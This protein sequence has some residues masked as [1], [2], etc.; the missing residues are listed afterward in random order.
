MTNRLPILTVPL[1]NPSP[2]TSIF[3]GFLN[4]Q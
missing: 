4:K 3:A 1:S 2:I